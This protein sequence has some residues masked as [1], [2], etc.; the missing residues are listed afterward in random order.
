MNTELKNAVLST[1]IKAQYDECVKKLLG[2]KIILA[3]ILAKSVDEFCGMRPEE[4]VHL[5]EGEPLI[6]KVPVE[7]GLT[8]KI[9]GVDEKGNE[10]VG[11]NTENSEVYAGYV[12]F[13][14]IFY[15][16][17]KDGVSQI[18]INIEAQKTNPA[19][20]DILNRAIFYISRLISSQKNREFKGSNYNDIK[21]VYSIWI[22]MNMKEDSMNHIHLTN[23]VIMGD[24][25]WKGKLEL[26]NIIMVGVS[27]KL[28]D[29]DENNKLHRLL[30]TLLS[31]KIEA[32]EKLDILEHEYGI[33]MEESIEEDVKTMCNLSEGIEERAMETG[34]KEGI[35]EGRKAGLE[36]GIES[37]KK[38]QLKQQIQKKLLKG[39][40]ID[41][42]AEELEEEVAVIEK[43]IA[44]L[45]Q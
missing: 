20:Y 43:V 36:I 19:D 23:D 5:I 7:L 14:I 4:V 25:K 26:L 27:G 12:R 1:D 41:V 16:R 13:D 8:N 11:L 40:D 44:E 3:H 45:E 6:S 42:I 10:I 24:Y 30:V 34:R 28:S 2:H 38:E 29:K 15:V 17:T 9:V 21:K 35:E 31:E 33:A 39:K 32:N 18:I 22:C 37:G